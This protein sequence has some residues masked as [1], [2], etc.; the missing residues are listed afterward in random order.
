MLHFFAKVL[1]EAKHFHWFYTCCGTGL[2]SVAPAAGQYVSSLHQRGDV[3]RRRKVV[4]HEL[5]IEFSRICRSP[6]GILFKP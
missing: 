2:L 4:V 1:D 5:L 6:R 3:Y